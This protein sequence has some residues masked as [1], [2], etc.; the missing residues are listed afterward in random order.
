M[1]KQMMHIA[2][3]HQ[4]DTQLLFVGFKQVFDSLKRGQL[5][6]A[7]KELELKMEEEDKSQENMEKYVL[8]PKFR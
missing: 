3:E 1:V 4:I 6:E 8:K 7:L 2:H 5:K